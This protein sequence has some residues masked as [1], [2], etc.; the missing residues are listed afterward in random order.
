MTRQRASE[1]TYYEWSTSRWFGSTTRALL[2]AK[3]R[4]IFREMIDLCF[5]TGGMPKDFT[6]LGRLCGCEASDIDQIW[7][8]LKKHFV[9]R[10]GRPEEYSYPV[11]DVFRRSTFGYL[12]AQSTNGRV[13]GLKSGM[14]RRAKSDTSEA[15][16]SRVL[17]AKRSLNKKEKECFALASQSTTTTKASSEAVASRKTVTSSSSSIASSPLVVEAARRSGIVLDDDAVRRIVFECRKI[18]RAATEDEMAYFVA[19][20]LQQLRNRPID[21]PIG[22]LIKAVPKYFETPATELHRFR[23]QKQQEREGMIEGARSIL[24]DPTSSE[25]DRRAAEQILSGVA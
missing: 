19:V 6:I 25:S 22:L 21:N 5:A 2:D 4:G 13:G 20:K 7:P 18:D 15:D 17:Q 14:A 3:G 11:A 12:S 16:A 1:I 24:S 23:L 8:L 10:K 9:T